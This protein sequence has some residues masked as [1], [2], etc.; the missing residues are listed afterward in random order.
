M[1]EPAV[2]ISE[3]CD[4]RLPDDAFLASFR[5]PTDR[6]DALA[7]NITMPCERRIA[8]DEVEHVY[9]VDGVR[10]PRSVTGFLREFEQE[11]DAREA[12]ALMQA[13]RNLGC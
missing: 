4:W 2:S 1:L 13:G 10:V 12:I 6:S 5:L 9:A 3:G 8:F 11:F 7:Q